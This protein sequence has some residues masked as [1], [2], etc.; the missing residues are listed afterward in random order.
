MTL[1]D[2]DQYADDF[3]NIDHIVP[4]AVDPSLQFIPSNLQ[5]MCRKHNL[6]KGKRVEPLPVPVDRVPVPRTSAH[7]F[8]DELGRFNPT[9]REWRR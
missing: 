9:S 3:L 7:G 5:P 2:G 4:Y 1:L 8:H 6:A